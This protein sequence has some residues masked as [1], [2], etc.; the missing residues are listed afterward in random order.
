MYT[1]PDVTGSSGATTT[2]AAT[3]SS[4][5]ESPQASQPPPATGV[6][7]PSRNVSG[8]VIGAVVAAVIVLVVGSVIVV[9]L[10]ITWRARS[11]KAVLSGGYSISS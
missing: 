8:A 6:Y 1:V 5:T 10:L 7:D 11:G 4:K 3:V 2:L 9:A